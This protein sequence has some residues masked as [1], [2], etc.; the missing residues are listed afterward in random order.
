MSRTEFVTLC[1]ILAASQQ[2]G[3]A[4]PAFDVINYETVLAVV[5][6]ARAEQAPVILMILPS[7]TPPRLEPGLVSLIRTEAA[8]AG[9]PVCMHLDHATELEQ[10]RA[11]LDLGFS[12]VMIDGSMLPLDENI[13]L[14]AQ[15]VAAAPR[16]KPSW[17][18]WAA[19]RRFWAS[20][21]PA[22]A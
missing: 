20:R 13:A 2:A 9:V 19:A 21:R 10:V 5:D 18:M 22:A 4:V 16:W 1:D 3:W 11:A 7:H 8:Q 15:V 17:G 6:G 12:S 14:T